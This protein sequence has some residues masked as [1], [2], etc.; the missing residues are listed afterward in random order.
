MYFH[1]NYVNKRFLDAFWLLFCISS[2]AMSSQVG[3]YYEM[4]L[5]FLKD[6]GLTQ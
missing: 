4:K 1:E 2:R 3:F 5:F 6:H